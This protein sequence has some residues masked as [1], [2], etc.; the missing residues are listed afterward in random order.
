MKDAAPQSRTFF[1]LLREIVERDPTQIAAIVRGETI[2]YGELFERA[3]RLAMQLAHDG[4]RRGE[5]IG[6][7]ATN[8]REWLELFFAAAAIG[9]TLVPFSTWSTRSELEFLL[10]DSQVRWLLTL[11]QLDGRE[12]LRD[13]LALR[14]TTAP[15]LEDVV[16]L[17]EDTRA[18][19]Y[20][21]YFERP[22][23][24]EGDA[25]APGADPD[26]TLVI[27]YT[28]GSS[29]RPKA[30]PL[31]HGSAIENGFNIGERQGLRP[32]D[33]IFV[34]VPL[35]WS[36][37]VVNALPAVLTHGATLVL[38]ERFEPDEA[39]S[40][41]EEH[42]CTAIY[43]LP[44]ITNALLASPRFDGARPL[45]LRTGVTIGTPQDMK[46]AAEEL[47]AGSIC[48]IYG[49]T[50]TY[51][52]CCVT[53][54]AWPL[55][56][57]S[58]SQGPALPGVHLRVRDVATG[59]LCAPG[60]VG[61]IEVKG[62]LTPGYAGHSARHNPEVFDAEGFFRTGDLGSLDAQGHLRFV[63][64]SSEMIKRSGINVSPA[65]VE[66][67]LQRH[68]AV[69]A[70][71]V[72]GAPDARRDEVIVAFVV[73]HPGN[74]TSPQVLLE[75]CREELSRYKLPDQLVVCPELP[76]T[77]TG[78]LLRRELRAMATRLRAG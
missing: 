7:L 49:S 39:V 42:R 76:L 1:E 3:E 65:E 20:A 51:G 52:N 78:K 31:L 29:A 2:S 74:A 44:A 10:E 19:S 54:N 48:N 64:R 5:R 11:P 60:E 30:V 16:V 14:Q 4:V 28:S 40:L 53:P 36:Y 69:A 73:L 62:H 41:L 21:T 18:E 27:L 77:P 24:C 58:E 72:T 71:G 47:G 57:R 37:G 23:A 68:P 59:S 43:T 38:Q 26:S 15:Q 22:V 6:V 32:T 12:L 25:L 50:E 63:G 75:H 13:I 34:P 61:A 55:S 33:R 9:A 35:F 70:V 45:S 8:R 46:R 17:G 66:E 56:L 67:T